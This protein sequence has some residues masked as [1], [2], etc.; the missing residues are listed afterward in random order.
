MYEEL[1]LKLNLGCGNKKI[2][3]FINIDAREESNPDLVYNIKNIHD[4]YKDVDLIYACHVL[5]HFSREDAKIVLKNWHSSLKNGGILR[6]AV[7]NLEAVFE[8]YI[9]FKDFSKIKGFL[10]GGQRNKFDFHLFGYDF[11]SIKQLLFECGFKDIKKYDWKETEHSYVDDYSQ[12]YLP[13][14]DKTN[15]ILMS[16]NIEAKKEEN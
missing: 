14:M 7:P 3:G 6:I 5:E 9:T 4:I 2:H 1:M 11:I 15:G 12:S 8:H 10:Y 13:H 16:L